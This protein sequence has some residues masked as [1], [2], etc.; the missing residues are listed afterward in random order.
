MELPDGLHAEVT[1]SGRKKEA[2]HQC[3]IE[4]CRILDRLGELTKTTNIERRKTQVE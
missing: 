1:V 3:M 2:Q 4:A